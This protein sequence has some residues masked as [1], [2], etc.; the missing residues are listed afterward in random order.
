MRKIFST[1]AIA[2]AV[3]VPIA[4]VDANAAS[5]QKVAGVVTKEDMGKHTLTVKNKAGASVLVYTTKTTT[6]THLKNFESLKKGLH[7]AIKA[8][9]R[10]SDNT[11]WAVSI[12]KM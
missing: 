10:A 9:L 6:Y 12:A 11:L 3:A 5:F 2:T 4:A 1:I 8:E 7:V